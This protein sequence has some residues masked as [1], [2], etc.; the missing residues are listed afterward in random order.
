MR[1]KWP[2]QEQVLYAVNVIWQRL[3]YRRIPNKFQVKSILVVKL[4]EIGD[5]V[6]ATAVFEQLKLQ[7]PSAQ[8]SVLCKPFVKPLIANDPNIDH[9]ICEVSKWQKRYDVV[10]ELRGTWRTWLKSIL[11]WPQIRLSR[12]SVRWRNRGQQLHEYQT[13]ALSVIDLFQGQVM[14]TQPKLYWSNQDEVAVQ[15]WLQ[16]HIS[17]NMVVLH[18]GARK[19]LR[20]WGVNRFAQLADWL[21]QEKGYEVVWIGSSDEQSVIE[22]IQTQ[23]T[24]MSWQV[25]G[26]FSLSETACLLSKASLY[27]GNESGPLQMAAAL[28]L[29][30]VGLFGPGVPNVFYP[31]H[32]TARV[33]HIVLPCNPCDQMHCQFPESPC[34]QRISFESVKQAI[35]D[36]L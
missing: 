28:K 15:S 3:F 10:I 16:K 21:I 8:L 13:N 34:I 32:D 4:D 25:C 7:F 26:Q 17:K 9:I 22:N 24:Q 19:S 12:A 35:N 36:I 31:Q 33:L 1:I 20:Q 11:H 2:S 29:P 5:M 14:D 18:A 6:C 23:M 27:V 30:L